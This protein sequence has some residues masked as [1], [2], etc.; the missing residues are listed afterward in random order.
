[1]ATST[2]YMAMATGAAPTARTISE[3]STRQK[4]SK[5]LIFGKFIFVLFNPAQLM[6][7]EQRCGLRD[8]VNPALFRQQ[9]PRLAG[10]INSGI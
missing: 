2:K 5:D 8:P 10:S 7:L 6:L 3:V 1:M 9:L 4:D